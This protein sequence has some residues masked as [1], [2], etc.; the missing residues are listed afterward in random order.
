MVG[1]A[2]FCRVV[3]VGSVGPSPCSLEL[4][5]NL[6]ASRTT[7]DTIDTEVSLL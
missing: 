6:D 1:G 5:E 2:S 7:I 3:M 4:K